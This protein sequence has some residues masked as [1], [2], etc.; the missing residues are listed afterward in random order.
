MRPYGRGLRC[1][2]LTTRSVSRE[3]QFPHRHLI[4]IERY[5]TPPSGDQR[6][7]SASLACRQ[8]LHHTYTTRP[9]VIERGVGSSCTSFRCAA[10]NALV[11]RAG[12]R[13]PG[14]P[15]A[16]ACPPRRS[17]R[18]VG[19]HAGDGQTRIPPVVRHFEFWVMLQYEI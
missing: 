11:L 1:D 5:V 16:G 6:A 4:R 19:R 17:A 10:I 9:V 7:R 18:T 8:A 3:R 13:W 2:P 15:K 14:G 12:R